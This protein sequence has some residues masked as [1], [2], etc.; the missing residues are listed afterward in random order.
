MATVLLAQLPAAFRRLLQALQYCGHFRPLVVP[1]ALAFFHSVPHSLIRTSMASCPAVFGLPLAVVVLAGAVV[2][3]GSAGAAL[4]VVAIGFFTGAV[5]VVSVLNAMTP[6]L[7]A[8][9][10]AGDTG[11]FTR[12]LAVGLRQSMVIILPLAAAMIILAQPLVAVLLHHANATRPL[13]AG[14]VLAVLAAGLPG[15]TVFQVAVRGLQALQHARDTFVLYVA[16]NLA[17]IGLV[18][19]I[20]RHSLAGLTASVSLAYLF[21]AVLALGA[22]TY[23]GVSLWRPLVAGPIVR[24]AGGAAV[25]SLAMAVVYNLYGWVSGAGL[26]T[27]LVLASLAG[28]VVYGG[29]VVLTHRRATSPRRTRVRDE[30]N[31]S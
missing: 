14:T 16:Q 9:S 3:V 31:G 27:R 1:S 21:A 6:Q 22:L 5:V 4:S 2:S 15:F 7:A 26:I 13:A 29:L 18:V 11:G 30:I 17:T 28:V 10:T 20:G 8:L 24:A 12:R 25:A 23:R 19:L